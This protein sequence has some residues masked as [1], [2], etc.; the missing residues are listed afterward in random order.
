MYTPRSPTPPLP[1]PIL[2]KSI[3]NQLPGNLAT[4][5]PQALHPAVVLPQ[6]DLDGTAASDDLVPGLPHQ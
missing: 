5:N 2:L 1:F 3:L 4:Y 6:A